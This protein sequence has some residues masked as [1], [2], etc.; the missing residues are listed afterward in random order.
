MCDDD[1][2][3]HEFVSHY[4]PSCL[5][6]M[7]QRW[8]SPQIAVSNRIQEGDYEELRELMTFLGETVRAEAH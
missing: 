4:Y 2:I 1:G 5:E 8:I 6:A 3:R 7:R